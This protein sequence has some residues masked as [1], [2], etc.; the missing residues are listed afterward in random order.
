MIHPKKWK[1]WPNIFFVRYQ[2]QIF[3]VRFRRFKEEKKIRRNFFF[4]KF[5]EAPPTGAA[6]LYPACFWIDYPSLT[7][8]HS[9]AFKN[10]LLQCFSVDQSLERSRN[11]NSK[12]KNQTVDYAVDY[13]CIQNIC[14]RKT[15][16]YMDTTYTS[17]I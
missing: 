9:I 8:S 12:N 6:P 16:S 10:C 14:E 13:I 3:V 1:I 4:F 11:H 2:W 17:T 5:L 7:G 15:V